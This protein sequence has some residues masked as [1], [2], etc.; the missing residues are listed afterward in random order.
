MPA[1]FLVGRLTMLVQNLLQSADV[2]LQNL[3]TRPLL[4]KT[5]FKGVNVTDIVELDPKVLVNQ[6][7]SLTKTDL[8]GFRAAINRLIAVIDNDMFEDGTNLTTTLLDQFADGVLQMLPG[9]A[10]NRGTQISTVN[11]TYGLITAKEPLLNVTSVPHWLEA[12]KNANG[13]NCLRIWR[14][15]NTI[16]ITRYGYAGIIHDPV[17]ATSEPQDMF[18]LISNLPGGF[19]RIPAGS[20]LYGIQSLF[21]IMVRACRRPDILTA[22]LTG[23]LEELDMFNAGDCELWQ[24]EGIENLL[25]QTDQKKYHK[26]FYSVFR[27]KMKVPVKSVPNLT[28][29]LFDYKQAATGLSPIAISKEIKDR[30]DL[31]RTRIQNIDDVF[32]LGEGFDYLSQELKKVYV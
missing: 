12:T 17:G 14:D 28:A 6:L 31:V 10:V 20:A 15:Y 32:H 21:C 5:S 30:L 2:R 8:I 27:N 24:Q 4:F 23:T 16:A 13:T 18:S 9:S 11:W 25:S 29:A 7:T 26:E 19:R 1:A 22:A 3:I